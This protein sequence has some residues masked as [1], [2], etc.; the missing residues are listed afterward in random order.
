VRSAYARFHGGDGVSLAHAT[1]AHVSAPLPARFEAGE[2]DFLF[3]L[4]AMRDLPRIERDWLQPALQELR[5][6]RLR[7]LVR[8]TADGAVFTVERAQRWRFWRRPRAGLLA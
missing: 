5:A 2:G 7:S 1:A 3:D 8:D 6:G 4:A